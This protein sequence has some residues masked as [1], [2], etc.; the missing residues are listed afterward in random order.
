MA[1][2]T[3]AQL[4]ISRVWFAGKVAIVTGARIKIGYQIITTRFP[5]YA[6]LKYAQEGDFAAWQARLSIMGLEFCRLRSVDAFIKHILAT[7]TRVDFLINNA[8]TT[9][10]RT[11][12]FYA[13]IVAV[14]RRALP[15]SLPKALIVELE[16]GVAYADAQE[17][18]P[19]L[20]LGAHVV[21][22]QDKVAVKVPLKRDGMY[23]LPTF[24]FVYDTPRRAL[25][26]LRIIFYR[27]FC[28]WHIV[29]VLCFFLFASDDI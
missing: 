9:V 16:H 4:D 10:R 7:H 18:A 1:L 27:S 25:R 6:A 23:R 24:L 15:P 3:G 11:P 26:F 13:E 19:V 14:E 2:D 17:V 12:E 21:G 28:N 8:A 29:L 5:R 20:S 22:N